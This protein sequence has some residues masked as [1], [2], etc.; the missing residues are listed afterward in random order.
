MRKS[1]TI[2]STVTLTFQ[3]LVGHSPSIKEQKLATTWRQ[4]WLWWK[5]TWKPRIKLQVNLWWPQ[6]IFCECFEALDD[7]WIF[8]QHDNSSHDNLVR[9]IGCS[10]S[11][12]GADY[13]LYVYDRCKCLLRSRRSHGSLMYKQ[14]WFRWR[15]FLDGTN[16]HHLDDLGRNYSRWAFVARFC[17]KKINSP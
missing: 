6:R 2:Q 1:K 14:T 9:V 11:K 12:D 15:T 17:Q 16:E 3:P 8:S 10:K 5:F 7:T 13:Q 4:E